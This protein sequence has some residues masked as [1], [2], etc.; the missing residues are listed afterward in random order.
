MKN[1]ILFTIL[2]I[3]LFQLSCKK[4]NE[5]TPTESCDVVIKNGRMKNPFSTTG[6]GLRLKP[7]HQYCK[8]YIHNINEYQALENKGVYLQS[9]PMDEYS[10]LIEFPATNTAKGI[11]FLWRCA[12]WR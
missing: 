5:A 6:N 8:F 3:S 10:N 4:N 12:K 9:L 11:V 7:T 2:A 1:Y